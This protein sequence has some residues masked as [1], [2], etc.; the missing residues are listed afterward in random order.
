MINIVK[1]KKLKKQKKMAKKR[2]LNE[3]R[4]NKDF[5]YRAPIQ[6]NETVKNYYDKVDFD[7][8]Y[9]VDLI[10]NFP[11]DYDLGGEFRKYFLSLKQSS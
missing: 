11:N 7:P 6:K 8:Q 2:T 4:Q 10:K 1:Q 9:L 5:G 3:L